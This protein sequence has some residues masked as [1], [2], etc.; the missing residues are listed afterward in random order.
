MIQYW[1]RMYVRVIPFVAAICV[2]AAIY[3][4]M[5]DDFSQARDACSAAVGSAVGYVLARIALRWIENRQASAA[6]PTSE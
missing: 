1:L 4:A 2:V 5:T 6:L 3:F